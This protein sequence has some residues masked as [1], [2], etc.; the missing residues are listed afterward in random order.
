[1][2][3][4]TETRRCGTFISYNRD[5]LVGTGDAL[6][7]EGHVMDT[8][9]LPEV[10]PLVANSSAM[11][12]VKNVL[13]NLAS[14]N[15][16]VLFKGEKGSGRAYLASLLNSYAEKPRAFL[17]LSCNGEDDIDFERLLN[18]TI[19]MLFFDEI[20]GAS[21]SVQEKLLAFLQSPDSEKV[22][23]CCSA[24][25]NLEMLAEKNRFNRDLYYR[26]ALLPLSVPPLRRRVDDIVPL[27]HIFLVAH[28][29]K[30]NKNITGFSREATQQLV[31]AF[32]PGNV[33]EL[34]LCIERACAEATGSV[35]EK[36]AIRLNIS[37]VSG[38]LSDSERSLKSAVDRFKK[39][40]ITQI[41]NEVRWS[42]TEAAKILD[43][44]RTYLSRLIKDLDIK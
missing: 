37:P 7:F 18:G 43:I 41:L 30:Y 21:R 8:V 16:P 2:F 1:M 28:A 17:R 24:S 34:D 14:S 42:Q 40:Y 44:Q 38:I 11:R 39:Q 27:A 15:V 20:G 32:W 26:L 22:R 31:S 25:E 36:N 3:G 23:I 10:Q 5:V 4:I 13:R 9:L 29:R 12:S 19:G 33:S 6:F 35:L